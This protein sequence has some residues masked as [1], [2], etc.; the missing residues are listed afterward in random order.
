M[1]RVREGREGRR[2]GERGKEEKGRRRR[3]GGKE[4]RW[5]G[6]RKGEVS[7]EEKIPEKPNA[8]T[9]IDDSGNLDDAAGP[10]VNTIAHLPLLGSV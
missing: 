7:G 1:R 9:S 5:E 10:L 8:D 4:G 6:G 2:E 3:E